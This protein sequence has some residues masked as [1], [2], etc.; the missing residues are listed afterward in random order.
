[1]EHRCVRQM[2]PLAST[3]SQFEMRELPNGSGGTM[4]RFSGYASV[5]ERGYAIWQPAIGDY[6]EV[7]ARGAFDKTLNESPDVSFKVNHEGLPMAKTTAGDLIL[8]SDS[9]GLYTEARVNPDRADVLLMRQAIEAGHL[10]EM[11]FAFRVQRQEWQ[12]DGATRR[13]TEVNLNQGD[14]SVVEFGAN[15]HTA[16]LLALRAKVNQAGVT[17]EQM[18]TAFRALTNVKEIRQLDP[19]VADTLSLLLS[20]AQIADIALDNQ[21][22]ILADL[23]G[24]ENPDDAQDEAME[25]VEATEVEPGNMPGMD[26]EP[27]P[28]RSRLARAQLQAVISNK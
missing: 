20:L 12:D 28:A 7:I 1:M 21:Q 16:G 4:I 23:L 15:P 11:S 2:D 18:T 6:T 24:I 19:E 27:M 9:T 10:N 13:I 14:V 22:D 5:I 3:T 8:A 17:A 25:A 26:A